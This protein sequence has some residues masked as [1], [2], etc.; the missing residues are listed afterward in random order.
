MLPDKLID[1][2]NLSGGECKRS[3]SEATNDA[4]ET[5]K[6]F[7]TYVTGTSRGVTGNERRQK[8][9]R[10]DRK[11]KVLLEILKQNKKRRK[12]FGWWFPSTR[13]TK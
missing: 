4:G 1:P 5:K 7:R 13:K 2:F 12:V 11:S 6:T 10:E 9:R 8:R 3:I